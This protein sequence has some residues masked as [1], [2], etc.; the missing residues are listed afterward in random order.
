MI[1]P[2]CDLSKEGAPIPPG[3][4]LRDLVGTAVTFENWGSASSPFI[5]GTASVQFK[6]T[7][8]SCRAI[9]HFVKEGTH[10]R[11]S[12]REYLFTGGSWYAQK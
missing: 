8:G 7:V 2:G 4:P 10:A 1:S 3:V 12:G 6:G 11:I 5:E 9:P